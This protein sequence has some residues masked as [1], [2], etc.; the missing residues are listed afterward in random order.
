MEGSVFAVIDTNVIVSALIS[1]DLDS[2]PLA[3]MARVYSGEI[4]PVFND[5]IINEYK[6]VLS[7]EKFH[8]AQSDID[9]AISIITNYGIHLERTEVS[10]ESFP[11]PKDIVFYEVKM[12]KEDAYLVTGNIKHFPS[13][14]C[15]VTPRKM[16]QILNAPKGN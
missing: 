13:K 14:P 1:K 7:R 8:L 4:T 16:I 9:D 10:D 2:Y 11:D 3:V 5:E 6:E 15:V 12:S